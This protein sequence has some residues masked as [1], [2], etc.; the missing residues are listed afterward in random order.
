MCVY[1]C[2]GSQYE[3]YF[4]FF[5]EMYFL[6]CGSWS[7]ILEATARLEYIETISLLLVFAL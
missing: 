4:F 5:S 7:K 2:T 6:L 1:E 3:M